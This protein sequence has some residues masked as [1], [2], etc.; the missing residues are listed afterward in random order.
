[1]QWMSHSPPPPSCLVPAW[2]QSTDV[3][4]CIVCGFFT[5]VHLR[6]QAACRVK[7]R[8]L[9]PEGW[10]PEAAGCEGGVKGRAMRGGCE[11]TWRCNWREE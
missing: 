3:H 11:E 8:D 7:G 2:T 1:M 9:T 4:S 10:N 5:R 6:H